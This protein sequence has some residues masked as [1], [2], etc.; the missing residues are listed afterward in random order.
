MRASTKSRMSAVAIFAAGASV[1]LLP[2]WITG[3]RLPLQN[4]WGTDS[5]DMPFALVPFS[6]YYVHAVAAMFIVGGG[7]AGLI[8]AFAPAI[9]ARRWWVVLGVSAVQLIAVL[10]SSVVT[11]LGLRGDTESQ[12]YFGV[13]LLMLVLSLLA[14]FATCALCSVASGAAPARTGWASPAWL[15]GV[16]MFAIFLG[17]WLMQWPMVLAPNG[18]HYAFGIV[19]SW[20]SPILVGLAIVAV[21][22]HTIGRI[23]AAIAALLLLWIVPAALTATGA[24]LGSRV[25]LNDWRSAPEYALMVFRE[26]LFIVDISLRAVIIAAVVAVIGLA[27]RYVLRGRAGR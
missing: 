14:A 9:R 1:G 3:A 12:L 11:L 4:L 26:A 15:I 23:A 8:A 24:V 25:M 13:I 21:G 27:L 22:V 19:V 16:A 17:V 18:D 2:W 7:L 6:Q 20:L 5:L 10:Q